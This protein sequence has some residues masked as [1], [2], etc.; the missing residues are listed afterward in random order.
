MG[1]FKKKK[2]EPARESAPAQ[3]PEQSREVK[4]FAADFLPEETDILAVTG[5][6]G[7]DTEQSGESG[8]WKVRMALTAWKDVYTQALQRGEGSLEALVDDNLLEHLRARLP[9]DFLIRVTVRPC[10]DGK[11]FLMTDLP[12]PDFE[13]ELKAI[14]EEQK[15]PVT[16]EADGLGTFTLSR[17]MNWFQAEVD[18]TAQPV[19]LVFDRDENQD[20]SLVTA[21]ALMEN[22]EDWDRRVREFAARELLEKVNDALEE[23]GPVTGEQLRDSLEAES[24]QVAGD[25]G[26]EFWLHDDELLWGR[27][28][29]VSGSLT[30][31]PTSAELEE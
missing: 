13:P 16:L 14:L 24:V 2:E 7:L 17:T 30:D 3:E 5:A 19:Q 22:R 4:S 9:R 1:L 31:G 8:L 18:W 21:R 28:I 20:D 10:A 12:K 29:H 6:T 27:A 15:K 11:R 25:G 23:D 26:V